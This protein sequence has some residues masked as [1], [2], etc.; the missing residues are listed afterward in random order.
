MGKYY[1]EVS[2]KQIVTYLE[3]KQIDFE[4]DGNQDEIICGFS[5]LRNYREGTITWINSNSLEVPASVS[6][7]IVQKGVDVKGK[8]QIVSNN[9]K[10][11]FFTIIERFWGEDWELENLIG[12]G[13]VIGKNVFLGENVRIGCNC[14]IVDRKSV[15]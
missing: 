10:G 5:S 4:V 1:K 7:C 11:L 3:E 12:E 9:S 14:S 2:V 8:T 6:V 15:V 13:T